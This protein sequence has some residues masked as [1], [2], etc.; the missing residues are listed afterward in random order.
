MN[1]FDNG[2]DFQ[3]NQT[4][5]NKKSILQKTW[6]WVTFAGIF[7]SIFIFLTI[8]ANSDSKKEKI[9]SDTKL[10]STTE[11]TSSDKKDTPKP[12]E[13]VSKKEDEKSETSETKN[14]DSS[15]EKAMTVDY[16][17]LFQDYEDNPI[18]ADQKYRYKKLR[19][20]GQIKKIDREIMQHP[21]VSFAVKDYFGDVTLYF[22]R[23]EEPKITKLKKGQ[24]ITVEGKCD[25]LRLGNVHL[26]DCTLVE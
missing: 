2:I 8:I 15:S 12:E 24:K 6:V 13:K 11:N 17:T 18:A 26:S 16:K 5:K 21:Y 25:G 9:D 10:V 1:Q 22:S 19:V 14:S 7:W 23:D 3:N 4:T 20:S